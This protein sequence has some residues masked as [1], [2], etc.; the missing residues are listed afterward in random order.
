MQLHLY[1]VCH[2]MHLL[3][4]LWE[5]PKSVEGFPSSL[6]MRPANA[7]IGA[8]IPQGGTHPPWELGKHPSLEPWPSPL[9]C[10]SIFLGPK[11]FFPEM[12]WP[13]PGSKQQS[14]AGRKREFCHQ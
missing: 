13:D 6:T 12:L 1:N 10:L 2:Y 4:R 5:D 8:G 9:P 11:D 14:A 7:T 3:Q